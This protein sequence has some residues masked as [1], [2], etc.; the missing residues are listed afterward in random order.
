LHAGKVVAFPSE[1]RQAL[2]LRRIRDSSA[3]RL[4]SAVLGDVALLLSLTSYNSDRDVSK[5]KSLNKK[6]KY[7]YLME[8]EEW[9]KYATNYHDHIVSPFQE[10]VLN[11]LHKELK[12]QKTKNLVVADLGTGRGDLIPFL[13]ENFKKVYAIDFSEKMIEAAKEKHSRYENVSFHVE[14][15]RELNRLKLNLDCAIAVNSVL[16]PSFEDVSRSLREIYNSLKRGGKFLGIFPSME[17]TLYYFNLVYEREYAKYKDEKR[18]MRNAT[19]ISEK[20]KINVMNG[21]FY[22]D[23]NERQKLYYQF[24]LQNR[25]SKIG[26][27]QISFNRVLYPWGEKNGSY[28]DFPGEPELWDWYV[29]ARK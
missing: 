28:V 8:K 7:F 2:I 19:R 24:E 21:V 9:N 26:F 10:G 1:L 15:M 25:L 18:A 22:D 4:R 12:K 14:D 11:P 20:R 3:P 23:G 29:V 17:S 27:K 13:A 5:K 6:A 16:H